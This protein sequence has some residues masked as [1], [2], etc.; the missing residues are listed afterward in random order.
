MRR[1]FGVEEICLKFGVCG[2]E[3]GQKLRSRGERIYRSR[4]RVWNW[5][6]RVFFRSE[7]WKEPFKTKQVPYRCRW[8]RSGVAAT[9]QTVAGQVYD[10]RG[11]AVDVER[12]RA[13]AG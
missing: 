10:R 4:S 1:G 3:Y 9:T 6:R 12:V 7:K 13:F 8:N 11:E 2:G 5:L